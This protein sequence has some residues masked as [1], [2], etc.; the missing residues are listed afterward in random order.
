MCVCNR[1]VGLMGVVEGSSV[2]CVCVTGIP[3]ASGMS[4]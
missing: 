3:S 4:E 1:E 2:R